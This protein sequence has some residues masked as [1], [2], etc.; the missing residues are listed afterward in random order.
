M[1][2]AIP[3]LS[4]FIAGLIILS[5]ILWKELEAVKCQL[6]DL[7]ESLATLAGKLGMRDGEVVRQ[8]T[9]NIDEEI[10]KSSVISE[11]R[12]ARRR[13]IPRDNT[14]PPAKVTRM[15]FHR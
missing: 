11:M 6:F 14:G 12:K 9:E 10:E 1:S 15:R 3:V 8:I 2:I 5:I 13:T 7:D 4:G